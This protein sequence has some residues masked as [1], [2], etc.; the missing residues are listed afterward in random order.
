MKCGGYPGQD[1]IWGGYTC[2]FVY[3][4]LTLSGLMWLFSHRH[5]SQHMFNDSGVCFKQ[6]E[7]L[8]Y[9][10]GYSGIVGG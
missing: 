1:Y 3:T 6:I 7:A 8:L 4:T 5:H 9:D 2:Q 10:G